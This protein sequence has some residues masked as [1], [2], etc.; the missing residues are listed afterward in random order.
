[1]L[2]NPRGF[3]GRVAEPAEAVELL[4]KFKR[5]RKKSCHAGVGLPDWLANGLVGM[6]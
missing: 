4:V 3:A 2:I 1:M 6:T 5:F